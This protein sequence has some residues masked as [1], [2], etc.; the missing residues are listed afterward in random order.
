MLAEVSDAI[1]RSVDNGKTWVKVIPTKGFNDGGVIIEQSEKMLYTSPDGSIF[2]STDFGKSWQFD[3]RLAKE[4]WKA[5]CALSSHNT[6]DCVNNKGLIYA[7]HD[8]SIHIS[9]NGGAS[10]LQT[11]PFPKITGKEDIFKKIEMAGDRIFILTEN[12][13]LVSSN[14]G[15]SWTA[16]MTSVSSHLPGLE[17]IYPGH[18]NDI[19]SDF[20]ENIYLKTSQKIYMSSDKGH[21]WNSINWKESTVP[22]DF[23]FARQDALYFTIIDTNKLG[24]SSNVIYRAKDVK[25]IQKFD[26]FNPWQDI[27]VKKDGTIYILTNEALYQTQD[28]GKHWKKLS[29]MD[30]INENLKQ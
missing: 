8:N 22:P 25:S 14:R 21:H 11:S 24:V 20:K 12:S 7:Y 28:E 17:M 6:E 27:K 1:V 4:S 29:G 15:K 2:K 3:A 5:G 18:I 23:Y 30:A 9:E 16:L 19:F 10:W 13:L 26:F